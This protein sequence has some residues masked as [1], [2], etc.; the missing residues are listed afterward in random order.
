MSVMHAVLSLALVPLLGG[1][2][3][4][5]QEEEQPQA[6]AA[7]PFAASSAWN[8]PIPPAP[9]V[10]GL[11]A[12]MVAH[13]SGGAHPAIANLYDYGVPVWEADASTPRHAVKCLRPWGTCELERQLVPVPVGAHPSSGSDGAMVVVDHPSGRAYEFFEG[14][15]AG[16][17]WTAGWGGVVDVYGSGTPGA[18]V[19][20]GVSRLAG[21]VRI[22]E[23]QAGR[24]DHALVFSTDNACRGT[25]RFPASKT[26]GASLRPDCVPEGA[27]LQL[28]PAVDVE[29]LPGITPG[30]RIVA[31]ALQTYGAYAI[32]N[33][34]A[35]MAFSF[36]MPS[37]E[38]DPYAEL[39][40]TWDYFAMDRIP[41]NR[42]R[43][44][45]A[46]DGG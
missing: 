45:R 46:W 2:P 42:L 8:T 19:G 31:R 30:E 28:D 26:D 13:L 25:R 37:G 7:R 15:S 10:D 3:A 5:G 12:L 9:V 20:A 1:I 40:F 39:G 35:R 24:I 17:A 11:S 38:A 14:R 43:V 4:D 33:G 34:G 22:A 23:L 29:A 44:L 21:V 18:A 27:R 41:W 6:A 32:D 16:A 36:E